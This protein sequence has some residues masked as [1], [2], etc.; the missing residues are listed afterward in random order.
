MEGSDARLAAE[1]ER[2][3]SDRGE[4]M[5]VTAHAAKPDPAIKQE[6]W[7]RAHGDG[8]ESL[9]VMRAAGNGFWWRS[10]RAGRPVRHTVLCRARRHVHEIGGGGSAPTSAYLSPA[11]ASTTTCGVVL[12]VFSRGT[13]ARCCGG[14]SSKRTTSCVAPLW[15]ARLPPRRLFRGQRADVF[16]LLKPERRYCLEWGRLRAIAVR[17]AMKSRSGI[18][19]RSVVNPV[20]YEVSVP[21]NSGASGM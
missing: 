19:K 17:A 20:M 18:G 3:P 11:T 15:S 7:A 2:D 5:M 10:Q 6:V 21:A 1:R 16:K 4:R 13:S 8:Y 12:L 9:F 14:C